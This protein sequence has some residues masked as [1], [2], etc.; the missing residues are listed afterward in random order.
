MKVCMKWEGA[1]F[2]LYKIYSDIRLHKQSD[3]TVCQ[4]H[5]VRI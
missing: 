5:I 4:L 1:D 3:H 2:S